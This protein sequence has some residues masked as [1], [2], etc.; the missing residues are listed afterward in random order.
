MENYNKYFFKVSKNM[1]AKQ[2]K[3]EKE[4]MLTELVSGFCKEKLNEEYEK[5]CIELIQKLGR[6]RSA[7]FM[8][9]RLEIWAAS[10]IYTVG[11]LNFLFD[12]SFEPYI[13]S[14][15]IHDYFDT[16]TSTVGA[17]S[18]LIRDMFKLDRIFNNELASRHMTEKNPLNQFVIVDEMIVPIQSLPEEYQKMVREA[19]ARGE[20]ISFQT[21]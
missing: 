15:D 6:K 20:D 7:P 9:G 1:D 16:K 2:I 14:S 21:S 3:K 18:K 4:Q 17:K 13:P 10:I 19:R 8:T 12:K 11:A 5:L